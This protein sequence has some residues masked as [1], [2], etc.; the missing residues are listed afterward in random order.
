MTRERLKKAVQKFIKDKGLPNTISNDFVQGIQNALSGLTP[1]GVNPADLL[2][3]LSESNAPCTV[4][5]FRSRFE[6]FV[7]D[8]IRGKDVNKVRIVIEK[9]G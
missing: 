2:S 4:E 8:M 3:S 6:N 5:Q 1:I 7:Q 9:G